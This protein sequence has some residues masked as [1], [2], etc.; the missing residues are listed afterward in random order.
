MLAFRQAL[1]ELK[2]EGGV[3]AREQRYQTNCRRL[4]DGM[5]KLGFECYLPE[6]TPRSHHHFVPLSG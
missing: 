3:A 2:I 4:I 6:G 1:E 5:T